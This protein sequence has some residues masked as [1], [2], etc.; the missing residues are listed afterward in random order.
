M[1]HKHHLHTYVVSTYPDVPS[2]NA[3]TYIVKATSE[4]D[5][6]DKIELEYGGQK[7]A[8]KHSHV[9]VQKTFSR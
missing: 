5:A 7:G 1:N 9:T 2:Y 3:V 4:E 8:W 6:Y